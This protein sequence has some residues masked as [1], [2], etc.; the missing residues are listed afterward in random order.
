M[1][2]MSSSESWSVNG[3]KLGTMRKAKES[4]NTCKQDKDGNDDLMSQ[5]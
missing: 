4:N 1:D 5:G 3:L 2:L